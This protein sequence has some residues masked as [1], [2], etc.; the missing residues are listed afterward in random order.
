[1]LNTIEFCENREEGVWVQLG[2]EKSA[3]AAELRGFLLL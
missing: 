1:M 3:A 2:K